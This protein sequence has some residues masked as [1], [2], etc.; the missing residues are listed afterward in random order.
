MKVQS[1]GEY[2]DRVEAILNADADLNCDEH[3]KRLRDPITVPIDPRDLKYLLSYVA[4]HGKPPS[5]HKH[6]AG[7]SAK[8]SPDG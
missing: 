2:R 7:V 4:D 8:E 6:G 1:W 3:G 5:A